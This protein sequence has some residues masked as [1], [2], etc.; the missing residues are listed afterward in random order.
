MNIF[1]EVLIIT[2]ILAVVFRNNRKGFIISA[3][4]VHIF[5]CGFRYEFVHGDLI[6]YKREFLGYSK[7]DWLDDA[8]LAKGRNT[9]FYALN[10][11]VANLTNDNFQVLLFLIAFI[12]ILSVSL[13]A[14]RYSQMPY[15]SFLLWSCF[16]FYKMSFYSIKQTL[17]MAFILFAVI[18]LFEHKR[19]WF[20]LMVIIAGFIHTPAFAFLPAYELCRAKKL[21]TVVVFYIIT[22]I[23]IFIFRNEIMAWMT[24]LYYEG[25]K[26][27]AVDSTRLGGKTLMMIALLLVGIVMCSFNYEKYRYTF[28]LMAS[29]SLLQ[30]FSV[31]DNVFTR[32]ADY[33]FQFIILYAPFILKQPHKNLSDV[34]IVYFDDE[35]QELLTAAFMLLAVVFYYRTDLSNNNITS[36]DNIVR[37]FRFFWQ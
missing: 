5:V 19:M 2:T 17:A 12:S 27:A 11:L 7:M 21:S 14:Y 4:A 8:I 16:G 6:A 15:I 35:S 26:Y 18:G 22:A 32:L 29:G 13:I 9:L 34:A 30:M 37:N 31:Y 1:W 33:Y 36:V 25:E 28:I 3:A 23:V 20:Y 10:K 24:D